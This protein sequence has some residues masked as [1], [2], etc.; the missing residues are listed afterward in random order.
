[1][2]AAQRDDCDDGSNEQVQT[3]KDAAM[4]AEEED[5]DAATAAAAS[6]AASAITPA[7]LA[8]RVNAA[9]MLDGVRGMDCEAGMRVGVGPSMQ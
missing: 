3:A 9:S 1:M 7:F 2:H 6:C 4:A 5:E 8:L